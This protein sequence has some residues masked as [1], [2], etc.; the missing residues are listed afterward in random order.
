MASVASWFRSFWVADASASEEHRV[1]EAKETQNSAL[2][3]KH[4]KGIPAKEAQ[5]LLP[6]TAESTAAS[7][8]PRSS[9]PTTGE[10]TGVN[11]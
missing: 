3:A 11:K 5:T 4:D 7:P 9:A 2:D 6:E 1:P 10:T 8:A